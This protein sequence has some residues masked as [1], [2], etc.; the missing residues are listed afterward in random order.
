MA[1]PELPEAQDPKTPKHAGVTF[2]DVTFVYDNRKEPALKNVNIAMKPG[3][4]TALVGPSGAGKSTVARLIPRFWDVQSGRVCIGGVD[5]REIA[6]EELMKQ[7]SFVFQQPFLLRDTLYQNI[8]L[9]NPSATD[10]QVEEAAKAAQAHDFIMELPQGYGTKAGDRGTRLSGGQRQRIT[11]ARAILQD[12]PIVVL[13]EATAFADPENE[14][15]IHAAIVRL[16][17]GKTL[18]VVAHRLSTIQDADQIVVL[19]KGEVAEVG[20]HADLAKK[21]GGLYAN[22]WTKFNEAQGW[23]L[24]RAKS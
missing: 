17:Q 1:V 23:G 11:I 10:A 2:E 9:G 12:T 14:A 15:N 3:K 5:V 6:T 18:I 4:I 8:L 7:I 20:K 16:T 13:D 24:R 22:L 21:E 19:N